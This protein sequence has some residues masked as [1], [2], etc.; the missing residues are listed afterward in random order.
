[1]EGQTIT[2]ICKDDYTGI[3]NNNEIR[4]EGGST[5]AM[6]NGDTLTLVYD[7]GV[8]YELSRSHNS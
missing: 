6:S 3:A 5:W 1:M 8:W 4:L 2:V 7:G